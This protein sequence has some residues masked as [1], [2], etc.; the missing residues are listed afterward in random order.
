MLLVKVL[1][2]NIFFL[3]TSKGHKAK[4]SDFVICA[5]IILKKQKKALS[6]KH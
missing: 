3:F 5:R 4:S 6:S 2:L 1:F